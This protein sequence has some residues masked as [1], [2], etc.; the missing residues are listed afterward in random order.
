MSSPRRILFVLNGTEGGANISAAQLVERL[1]AERYEGCILYPTGFEDG[2][3]RL[4]AATPRIGSAYLTSWQIPNQT[5][6]ARRIKSF[7]GRNI[8]SGFHLRTTMQI[9][10]YCRQ[11]EIDL[12]HTNTSTTLS[13][14]IA[15]RLLQKPHIWHI[16]EM[17]GANNTFQFP[18][19]DVWASRIF[20]G[21]SNQ[22]IANSDQSAHFFHQHLGPDA[23]T[24][25][26]NGIPEPPANIAEMAQEIRQQLGIPLDAVLL[27][28]V[29]N[30]SS[31]I[32]RHDHFLSAA[33]KVAQANSDVWI[34]LC[35]D[36]PD[37]PYM[38]KIRA[39]SNQSGLQDRIVFTGYV[40][41]I[42][43]IMGAIDI[44]GHGTEQESFGRIFV[45]AMMAGKP[46][47]APRGGGAE[48][49]VEHG[50]TGFLTNPGD[51]D[52]MAQQIANLVHQPKLRAAMGTAGRERALELYSMSTHVQ[53]VCNVY[54]NILNK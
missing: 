17:I 35:G 18:P 24:V 50:R 31:T 25:I 23:V 6:L 34:V 13:S 26:L 11:W 40:E 32:K 43:A 14:A 12:I 30:F 2:I 7:W 15:A 45:E 22:V 10:R 27:G 48:T 19:N 52:D 29:A 9:M 33:V 20:T 38:D 8:R 39:Q 21:L 51:A 42:W 44:L 36:M 3:E 16:R 4:I 28:M 41:N 49:I 53:S 47:V 37:T 54:D 5:S 46:V 1:P